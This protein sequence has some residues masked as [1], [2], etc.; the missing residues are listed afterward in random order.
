M[1]HEFPNL[2]FRAQKYTFFL[3]APFTM[4]AYHVSAVCVCLLN[5]R[6]RHILMGTITPYVQLTY[7]SEMAESSIARARERE[8]VRA[9]SCSHK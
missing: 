5:V 1:P 8:R 7:E 3:L 6:H 9:P 4:N 2:D